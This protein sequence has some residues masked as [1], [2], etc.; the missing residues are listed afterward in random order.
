MSGNSDNHHWREEVGEVIIYT[1]ALSA[2]ELATLHTYLA[3]K[4]DL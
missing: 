1:K 4:W 2:S 3:A